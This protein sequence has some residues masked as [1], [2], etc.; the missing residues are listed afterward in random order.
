V[1]GA[2]AASPAALVPRLGLAVVGACRSA[3]RS[4]AGQT[5]AV[6]PSLPPDPVLEEP[7]DSTVPGPVLPGET[8]EEEFFQE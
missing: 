2:C 3:G 7:V 8:V 6:V 1:I 4:A 5:R